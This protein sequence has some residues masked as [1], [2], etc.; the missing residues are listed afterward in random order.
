MPIHAS[1]RLSRLY[2]VCLAS[3]APSLVDKLRTYTFLPLPTVLHRIFRNAGRRH[4]VLRSR[5][6]LSTISIVPV[7]PQA[8]IAK[9]ETVGCLQIRVVLTMKAICYESIRDFGCHSP[10]GKLFHHLRY[11]GLKENLVTSTTHN[12]S[13]EPPFFWSLS[14][15]RCRDIRRFVPAASFLSNGATHATRDA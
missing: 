10:R 14:L 12:R 11:V 5:P 8:S 9:G 2:R 6:F 3:C 4:S 15:S 7:D 1:R 13:E